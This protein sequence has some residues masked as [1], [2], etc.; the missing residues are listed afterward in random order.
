MKQGIS[1]CHQ[2]CL[3]FL[4]DIFGTS[5]QL[6]TTLIT[7]NYFSPNVSTADTFVLHDHVIDIVL[8]TRDGWHLSQ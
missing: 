7:E 5:A 2:Q 3:Q 6:A 1:H 8:W 4:V